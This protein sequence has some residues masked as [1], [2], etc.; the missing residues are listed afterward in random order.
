MGAGLQSHSSAEQALLTVGDEVC[1]GQQIHLRSR[2]RAHYWTFLG[3]TVKPRA[4]TTGHMSVLGRSEM[5]GLYVASHQPSFSWCVPLGI[6][7][8]HPLGSYPERRSPPPTLVLHCSHLPTLREGSEVL[9]PNWCP[10]RVSEMGW[11]VERRALGSNSDPSSESI[12]NSTT[13]PSPGVPK[14][15]TQPSLGHLENI[16]KQEQ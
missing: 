1:P 10:A 4:S 12:M 3:L 16:Y 7:A 8:L 6:L 2:S 15:K 14:A 13:S 11:V 5:L 9:V